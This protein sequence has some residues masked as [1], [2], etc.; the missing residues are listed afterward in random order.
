MDVN[1]SIKDPMET[2]SNSCFFYGQ[3]SKA[4]DIQLEY[5]KS[6]IF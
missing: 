3:Q 6:L 5:Y 2:S 4:K 1:Q